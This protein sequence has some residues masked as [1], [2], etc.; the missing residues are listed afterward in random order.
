MTPR[1]QRAVGL[2]RNPAP[3]TRL[4]QSLAVLVGA[5]LDLVNH[6][7]NRC[8]RKHLLQLAGVEVGDTDRA[9]IAKL[10]RL[11]HPGP[12]PGRAARWPVDDVEVDVVDAETLQA[13]FDLC[14]RVRPRRKELRGDEHVL[15]RNAA[16]AQTL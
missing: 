10:A 4:E 16:L 1:S 15:A 5:E 3:A 9:R 2:E 12:R 14:N 8:A 6:G 13:P 11:L 7:H